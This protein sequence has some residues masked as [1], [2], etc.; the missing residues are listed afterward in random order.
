LRER[1]L[2][3][4][5]LVQTVDRLPRA[6]D[7]VVRKDVLRLVAQNHIDLIDKLPLDAESRRIA[8]Q[9]AEGRL[10]HSDRRHYESLS[11]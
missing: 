1:Q 7:G 9:V 6:A 2:P 4:P 11:A 10:N 8:M 5:N 3:V